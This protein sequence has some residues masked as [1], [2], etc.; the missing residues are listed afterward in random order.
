[1]QL[2]HLA[3]RLHDAHLE[4]ETVRGEHHDDLREL[5][6]LRVRL[7]GRQ[8][9]LA[10][11]VVTGILAIAVRTLV[12]RVTTTDDLHVLAAAVTCI[13]GL[14]LA[15]RAVDAERRATQVPTLRP[16][17]GPRRTPPTPTPAPD[18]SVMTAAQRRTWAS[19]ARTVRTVRSYREVF[20][21]DT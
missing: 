19:R 21:P 15:A 1:M 12:G 3:G 4:Q 18:V 10:V 6:L 11:L 5:A 17:F 20:G 9:A 16:F 8:V 2:V 13:P 7:R 14:A